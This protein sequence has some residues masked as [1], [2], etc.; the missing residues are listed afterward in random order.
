M[1][2]FEN[3]IPDVPSVLPKIHCLSQLSPQD[4]ISH[5]ALKLA[6]WLHVR[7]L[8]R[9]AS[10]QVI[11]D[12]RLLSSSRPEGQRII[13][14]FVVSSPPRSGWSWMAKV[15][16]TKCTRCSGWYLSHHFTIILVS[17][18]ITQ[19]GIGD[20]TTVNRLN[21]PMRSDHR[22]FCMLE[23]RIDGKIDGILDLSWRATWFVVSPE[24]YGADGQSEGEGQGSIRVYVPIH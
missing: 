10:W 16:R 2:A 7:A 18:S 6:W 15:T 12:C 14:A 20:E 17:R 19:N 8:T 5:T 9:A 21:S 11:G 24:D 22:Y 4:V 23:I 13:C 3:F 1:R